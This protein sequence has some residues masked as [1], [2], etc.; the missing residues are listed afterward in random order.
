MVRKKILPWNDV[1]SRS[2]PGRGIPLNIQ[3]SD[4]ET[5]LLDHL[6]TVAFCRILIFK[7]RVFWQT[8]AEMS[9]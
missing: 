8:E 3:I 7:L 1:F 5:S 6:R 2:R 4:G 9:G